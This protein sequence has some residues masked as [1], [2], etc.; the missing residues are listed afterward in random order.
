MLPVI[1]LP[2]IVLPFRVLSSAQEPEI[3]VAPMQWVGGSAGVTRKSTPGQDWRR[4]SREDCCLGED[5]AG[6]ENT[7]AHP[8]IGAP[9]PDQDGQGTGGAGLGS[10]RSR[11]K[12][13]QDGPGPLQ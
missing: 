10:R 8:R 6:A 11:R 9:L 2:V 5:S 3:Q 4:R 7:R 12:G 13:S 1:V